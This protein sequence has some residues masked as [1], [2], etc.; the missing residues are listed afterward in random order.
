MQY[1]SL[2]QTVERNLGIIDLNCLL[3]SAAKKAIEKLNLKGQLIPDQHGKDRIKRIRI[4]YW[5]TG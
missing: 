5:L 1:H 4:E 3:V 2:M